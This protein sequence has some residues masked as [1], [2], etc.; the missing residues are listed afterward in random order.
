MA[1]KV[2]DEPLAGV[3]ALVIEDEYLVARDLQ[4]MLEAAGIRVVGPVADS[5]SAR[6]AVDRQT[7]D[8][9]LLDIKL[10]HETIFAVA[11]ELAARGVPLVFVSGY[12]RAVLPARFDHVPYVEKPFRAEQLEQAIRRA[13][14][15]EEP[16]RRGA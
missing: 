13:I 1:K 11:D 12:D 5:G 16:P 8:A 2:E 9:A 7:A 15:G 4:R 10:G 6:E 14:S 3:R